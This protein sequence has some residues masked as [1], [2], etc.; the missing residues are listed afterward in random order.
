MRARGIYDC[1]V[2]PFPIQCGFR[3]VLHPLE[4]RLALA[5]AATGLP[6][7]EHPSHVECR[8]DGDPGNVATAQFDFP[9]VQ[10]GSHLM[11]Y[12]ASVSRIAAA[13]FTARANCGPTPE[14][15]SDISQGL[16]ASA[17]SSG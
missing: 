11:P 17:S 12:S 3:T 10:P 15:R 4:R 6:N 2:R 13:H 5:T 7:I 14:V 1:Q 9:G 8:V 16:G